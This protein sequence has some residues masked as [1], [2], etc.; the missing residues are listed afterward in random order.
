M[1]LR[2]DSDESRPAKIKETRRPSLSLLIF[3]R[4]DLSSLSSVSSLLHRSS[5]RLA[6]RSTFD[7]DQKSIY[8]ID[9]IL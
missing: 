4:A 5:I 9:S 8:Q 1:K 3:K 6:Y 7:T 2:R